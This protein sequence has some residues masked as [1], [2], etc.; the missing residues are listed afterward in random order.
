MKRKKRNTI[1]VAALTLP[2]LAADVAL[3]VEGELPF[4]QAAVPFALSFA[5]I[6]GLVLFLKKR[7]GQ[8]V[9]ADERS[10]KIEGRAFCYSWF[11]TLYVLLLFMANDRLR[12]VR[13]ETAQCLFLVVAVLV[14]SF[15]IFKAAL[16]REGDL[17]E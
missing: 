9:E 10:V 16:S 1:I 6:A 2:L 5:L 17:A 3:A 14:A 11:L 15:W 13:M 8:K 7:D 4:L 12:L